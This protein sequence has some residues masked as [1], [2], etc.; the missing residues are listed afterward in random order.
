LNPERIL[1]FGF[2]KKYHVE[3]GFR[4]SVLSLIAP[5][6]QE[7][8]LCYRPHGAHRSIEGRLRRQVLRRRRRNFAE[9][10]GRG[11]AGRR[12]PIR[13][14]VDERPFLFSVDRLH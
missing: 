11:A 8:A 12:A 14:G 4:E 7:L 3:R 13:R 5:V 1:G 10:R 2:A 6:T 9:A